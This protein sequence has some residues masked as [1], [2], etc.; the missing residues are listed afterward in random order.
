MHRLPWILL[1]LPLVA[2]AASV[3]PEPVSVRVQR[4]HRVVRARVVE[5]KVTVADN[6]PRRIYTVSRLEV[7]EALK[8]PFTPSLEIVQ[9]GGKY[10]LWELKVSG[11]AEL[12]PGEEAVFFLR[13]PQKKSPERCTLV[14]LKEGKLPVV[15]AADGTT[16]EVVVPREGRKVL[17]AFTRR[18]RGDAVLPQI[19]PGQRVEGTP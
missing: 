15:S 19:E 7:L 18:V 14:A 8:G 9:L 3:L 11:D 2:S 16:Q 1:I 13:C 6:N 17:E 5:S 12:V 10:G 4:A